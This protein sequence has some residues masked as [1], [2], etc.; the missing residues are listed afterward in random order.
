MKY[1]HSVLMNLLVLQ[2]IDTGLPKMSLCLEMGNAYSFYCHELEFLDPKEEGSKDFQ[3][4]DVAIR[5][6]WLYKEQ[7]Y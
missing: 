2:F 7:E 1:I 3:V 4:D 5:T 6:V